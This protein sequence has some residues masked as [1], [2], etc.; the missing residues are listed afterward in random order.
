MCQFDSVLWGSLGGPCDLAV[1][2]LETG[3]LKQA[4]HMKVEVANLVTHGAS[5]NRNK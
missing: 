2:G 5:L 3:L 1:G 4:E